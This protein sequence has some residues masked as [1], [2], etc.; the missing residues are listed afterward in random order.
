[1]YGLLN[2]RKSRMGVQFIANL[3]WGQKENLL[4]IVANNF[5]KINFEMNGILQA[6]NY[7]S[8]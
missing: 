6:T 5:A 3:V 8:T 1:M 4:W 2:C 7:W